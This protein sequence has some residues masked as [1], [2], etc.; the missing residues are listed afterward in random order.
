MIGARAFHV[1]PSHPSV[2]T[3]ADCGVDPVPVIMATR[4]RRLPDITAPGL[5]VLFVGINPGLR[6]AALGHHFAGHG[7]R[8]WPLLHASGLVPEPVTFADDRRLTEWGYGLTNLVARPTAGV[9]D[10]SW[11]ELARGRRA[12]VAKVRRLRPA[13]VALVGLTVYRALFPTHPRTGRITPGESPVTLG[14]ARIFVLPNP[15]GRN[16]HFPPARMLEIYRQLAEVVR[17]LERP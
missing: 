15:S 16:A 1:V 12:L 9:D 2:A 3:V 11:S 8:F 10:L 4:S 7:N 5:R 13:V 6:S 14:G 17:A